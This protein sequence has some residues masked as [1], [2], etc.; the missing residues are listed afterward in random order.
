MITNL[1]ASV[2]ITLVTNVVPSDNAVWEND[3]T[4]VLTTWPGQYGKRLAKTA[5]E[6]YLT[7][8]VVEHTVVTV[9][10]PNGPAT[11]TQD[12]TMSSVTAILRKLEQWEPAGIRTN[13][14]NAAYGT[15]NGSL[16]LPQ[17]SFKVLP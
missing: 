8:N 17:S 11:F 7:T 9:P 14:F 12:R 13:E 10:L 5:T 16:V 3:Y 2:V 4:M 1:I 15:I 6:S